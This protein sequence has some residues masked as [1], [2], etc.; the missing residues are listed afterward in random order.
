MTSGEPPNPVS[1]RAIPRWKLLAIA[2]GMSILVVVAFV[3]GVDGPFLFDDVGNTLRMTPA[4]ASVE[5]LVA[6][7]LSNESGALRRPV[8]NLSFSLNYLAGGYAGSPDPLAY[9]WTNIALHVLTTL[10]VGLFCFSV[11]RLL[12]PSQSHQRVVWI[13]VATA[14]I[15]AVHPL[16]VSTVLYVVQRMAILAGL[17]ALAALLSYLRFR[18]SCTTEQPGWLAPLGWSSLFGFF[19]TLSVLS[20][21]NGILVLVQAMLIAWLAADRLR[22]K[23]KTGRWQVRLFHW[24]ACALPLLLVLAFLIGKSGDYAE[25]YA[26]RPFSLED[27]LLTQPLVL[28]H[29]LRLIYIP[30]LVEMGLFLDDFPT[31][32]SLSGASVAGLAG[33]SLLF[34]LAWIARKKFK[35]VSFGILW[36]FGW[37]L[38]ESTALPLEMLFEHRNYMAML[39]PILVATYFGIAFIARIEG[40]VRV[41]A[42]AVCA[43]LL[44]A[45][46]MSTIRSYYWSDREFLVQTMLRHHPESARTQQEAA[47]IAVNIGDY[48]RAMTHI[49]LAAQAEP[50]DP[51]TV[52]L[53]LLAYCSRESVPEWVVEESIKDLL[54]AEHPGQALHAL[55]RFTDYKAT[56]RCLSV[57]S[58]SVFRLLDAYENNQHFRKT[59]FIS[60]ILQRARAKL[61][62]ALSDFPSAVAALQ[63]A[64]ARDPNRPSNLVE[65]ARVLYSAGQYDESIQVIDRIAA[66]TDW[67]FRTIHYMVPKMRQAVEE[68]RAQE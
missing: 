29:Y 26:M 46:V 11:V 35:L 41:R 37:H 19:L 5:E 57:H 33:I 59:P 25:T 27:R 20:K 48:I 10:L 15:W 17:F 40:L 68:A 12:D 38:L 63:E 39:G 21:E 45:V 52:V 31:Q 62:V 55:S 23:T 2:A 34:V 24:G 6:Y 64:V 67:E 9:K 13:A 32:T 44:L 22:A 18:R 1:G 14:A 53:R 49:D 30:S 56:G 51:A 65:L 16:Q 28:L 42:I 8:S 54:S 4:E 66:H 3:R 50:R 7:S 36:F 43:F 47:V 60:S 58:K 61:H